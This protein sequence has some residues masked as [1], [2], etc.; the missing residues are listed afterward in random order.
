M[1]ASGSLVGTVVDVYDGTGPLYIRHTALCNHLLCLQL[2]Q[3]GSP[4]RNPGCIKGLHRM[5]CIP[6]LG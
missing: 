2:F 3:A 5:Q 4:C 6:C 1:Q